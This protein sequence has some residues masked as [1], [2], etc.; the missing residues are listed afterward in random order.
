MAPYLWHVALLAQS[1]CDVAISTL[2]LLCRLYPRPHSLVISILVSILDSILVSIPVLLPLSSL[3]PSLPW[4]SFLF[5]LHRLSILVLF[6]AC[7]S[8]LALCKEEE[9]DEAHS[10]GSWQS[11]RRT[12]QE[13]GRV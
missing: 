11:L 2:V 12:V 4:S 13:V 5:H 9:R 3:S 6:F 1:M 10:A 8:C 7:S